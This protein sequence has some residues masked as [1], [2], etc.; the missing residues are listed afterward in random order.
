MNQRQDGDSSEQQSGHEGS[1]NSPHE[2]LKRVLLNRRQKKNHA[3]RHRVP[4]VANVCFL[5]RREDTT[6]SALFF[7]G[8][9]P[10][11]SYKKFRP[12][13]QI[14]LIPINDLLRAGYI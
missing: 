14:V 3:P 13:R 4:T 1:K 9:T 10:D 7:I 2:N 6:G 5:S 11:Q 8:T 12:L